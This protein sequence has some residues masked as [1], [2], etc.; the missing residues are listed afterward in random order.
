MVNS[1]PCAIILPSGVADM[2]KMIYTRIYFSMLSVIEPHFSNG[3]YISI[4]L[5]H[6]SFN[7]F[8]E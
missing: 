3:A 1:L 7:T 5:I 2:N 6:L 4:Q 8:T